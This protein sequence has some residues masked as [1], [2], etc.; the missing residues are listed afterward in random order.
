MPTSRSPDEPAERVRLRR[1]IVVVA[2]G[3]FATT[4][5]QPGVLRLPFQHILRSDLHVAPHEMA[6]FFAGAALAWYF[7]PLAGI[8]SDS[9]P[10]FGTRRRHYLVLS[11][12]CAAVLWLVVGFVPRTY[13]SLL[14]AVIALNAALVMGSTVT[15]GLLVEAGQRY[16]ATGRLTSVRYVVQ[17]L[18]TLL[19]GPLGGLLAVRSFELTA[20]IGALVASAIVPVV[21]VLLHEPPSARPR[22]EVWR[23][24]AR[25]VA[26]LMRSGPLWRA[27][28]LLGLVYAAPGFATAL[29]YKQTDTLRF[30]PEFIGMLA[31]ISGGLALCGAA[32]YGFVVPHLRL[33]RLVQ[34]GVGSNALAT[35]CY[36]FYGSHASAVVIEAQAGLFVTLAEMPLMDLA[37]RATPHGSEGLGFALMMSVRNA[38]LA[39]AD[40]LGA[41][42]IEHQWMSFSGVVV[43]N[44]GVIVAALLA[45]PAL[46]AALLDRRDERL[47]PAP[48]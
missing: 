45:V 27:V 2:T 48:A 26:T 8:V 3:V 24:A 5:A 14:A 17:N 10:L 22:A 46:P 6:A 31:F 41:W 19:A 37:A 12:T 44:A 35:L 1:W 33:R 23:Q 32:L 38:A 7:K 20:V 29:Y 39:L 40:M 42:L 9:F 47:P 30:T 25:E 21:L 15:G 4:L 13:A 11:G 34:V 36:L 16:G 43:L 28:G 18:C